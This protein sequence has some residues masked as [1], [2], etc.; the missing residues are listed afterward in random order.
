M[1]VYGAN[2][3]LE[4]GFTN[5]LVSDMSEPMILCSLN[6]SK[7]NECAVLN[8]RAQ[9]F[10]SGISFSEKL[11]DQT[12]ILFDQQYNVL[13]ATYKLS[14]FKSQNVELVS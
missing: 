14:Y 13:Y 6:C 7:E 12:D 3:A 2:I 1:V 8:G 5:H 11:I 10:A 9:W 4:I